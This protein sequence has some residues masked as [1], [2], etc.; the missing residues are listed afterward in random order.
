M[1]K[2]LFIDETGIPVYRLSDL[3]Y[4]V[5]DCPH[6]SPKWKENGVRVVR[7]FNIQDG[8]LDFSDGYYVSEE[9]YNER[10]RRGAPEP[11]D[12]IIS[13]EAPMGSAAIVPD[14][15]KCCLGQRL[16][17]LKVDRAICDPEYLLF[18]LNSEYVQTQMRRADA[19]GST[20]SNLAIPDLKEIKVPLIRSQH[21]LADCLSKL[22]SAI[23]L[24]NQL[25]DNLSVAA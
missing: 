2:P 23:E 22:N 24:N 5:I 20:V 12:I 15:L 25:N 6:S 19:T 7:N 3:C 14:G 18:A 11:G 13:R 1:S 17:L 8:R 10:I 9:C 21:E 16:V 4:A